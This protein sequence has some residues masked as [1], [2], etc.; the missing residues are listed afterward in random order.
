MTEMILDRYNYWIY[1]IL[2]MMGIYAMIANRH[3]VR[4]LIGLSIFQTAI[5]LFFIS[6]ASREG[7]TVP[8]LLGGHGHPAPPGTVYLNPLPHVL[9]LTAIV[10]AVSSTGV[11]LAILLRVHRRYGTLEEDRIMEQVPA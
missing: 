10:V 11:A 9:M 5:I 7:G 3:L 4:K 6:I 1:I 2:M 8:V